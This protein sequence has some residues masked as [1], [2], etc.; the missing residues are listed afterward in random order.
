MIVDSLSIQE[1][2]TKLLTSILADNGLSNA[3]IVLAAVDV[4]VALAS[5][6][7]HKVDVCTAFEINPVSLLAYEKVCVTA[8]A[9]ALIEEHLK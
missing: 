6:N 1:P 5:R 8:D 3:L 9:L 4:N 2:K 7:I